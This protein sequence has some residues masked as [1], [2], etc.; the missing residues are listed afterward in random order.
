MSIIIM[1][2]NCYLNIYLSC[3]YL[4]V[5]E[6]DVEVLFSPFQHEAIMT[7]YDPKTCAG[8]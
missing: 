6:T 2:S 7:E 5:A 4:K 8:S 3:F 1:G